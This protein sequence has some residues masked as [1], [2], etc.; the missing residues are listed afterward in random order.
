MVP[1]ALRA[2]LAKPLVA[3][4]QLEI[5]SYTLITVRVL[6]MVSQCVVSVDESVCVPLGFVSVKQELFELVYALFGVLYG[7]DHDDLVIRS[8][9][10]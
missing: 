8:F 9:V 10:D 5:T 3:T 4:N 2:R 6:S 1:H 7:F